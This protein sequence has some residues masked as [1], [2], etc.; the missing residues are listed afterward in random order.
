MAVAYIIN[1]D[2]KRD[3]KRTKSRRAR[4]NPTPLLIVSNPKRK[5]KSNGGKKEMAKKKAAKKNPKKHKAYHGG[6]AK[7]AVSVNPK[8]HHRKHAK[9]AVAV[10]P[11]RHHRKHSKRVVSVNPRRKRSYR[12]NPDTFASVGDFGKQVGLGLA[13]A[14]ATVMGTGYVLNAV[15]PT[16]ATNKAVLYISEGAV[17]GGLGLF[18]HHVAKMKDIAAPVAFGGALMIG[19]QIASDLVSQINNYIKVSGYGRVSGYGQLTSSPRPVMIPQ[20]TNIGSNGYAVRS[21]IYA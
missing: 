15:A 17:I 5:L 6:H 4:K 16:L 19:L 8:R 10:N 21:E 20:N 18:L 2:K 7:R 3:R 12:R 14:L 11:K 9:R 13:G 1:P